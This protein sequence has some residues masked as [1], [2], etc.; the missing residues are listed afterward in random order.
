[1]FGE[2]I[3][4]KP[5]VFK[6]SSVHV[7]GTKVEYNVDDD[8]VQ[9]HMW[10]DPEFPDEFGSKV[11]EGLSSFP[12]GTVIVDFV[13]EVQSWYVEVNSLAVKPTDSLVE[14]IVKKIARSVNNNG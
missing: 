7:D 14:T 10:G 11:S 4:I 9:F 3:N 6:E 5:V 13:P 1:M 12:K 8:R 2:G